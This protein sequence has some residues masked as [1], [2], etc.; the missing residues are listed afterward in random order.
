MG[1][2][3]ET[4]AASP[5]RGEDVTEETGRGLQPPPPVG[6]FGFGRG[7]LAQAAAWVAGHDVGRDS[8]PARLFSPQAEER[9]EVMCSRIEAMVQ[10]TCAKLEAAVAPPAAQKTEASK[11]SYLPRSK[12]R[13]YGCGKRGHFRAKCPTVRD[14]KREHSGSSSTPLEK[15][16]SDCRNFGHRVEDCPLT[17]KKF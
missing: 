4:A 2:N 16:Y 3:L 9:L 15:H 7:R 13:C 6:A 1:S 5:R 14:R 12:E 10:Q 11:V 8:Q 17:T